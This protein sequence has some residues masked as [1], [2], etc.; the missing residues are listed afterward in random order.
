M[1]A[2]PERPTPHAFYSAFCFPCFAKKLIKSH[3]LTICL[4]NCKKGA[5]SKRGG[6]ENGEGYAEGIASREK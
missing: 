2:H 6:A 3:F 4:G 1:I 5:K